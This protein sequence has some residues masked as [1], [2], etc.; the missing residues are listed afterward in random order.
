[1]Q[2]SFESSTAFT[3]RPS[4]WGEAN[5]SGTI[6]YVQLL[7]SPPPKP[8]RTRRAIETNT[9]PAEAPQDA[10][11]EQVQQAK[12]KLLQQKQ[13]IRTVIDRLIALKCEAELAGESYSVDSASDCFLF[14][15]QL[16]I[17]KRP[18]IYLLENGNFQSVWRNGSKEQVSLQFFGH[19]VVQFAM[20]ALR[21][22]QPMARI[23]GRDTIQ[24][25]RAKIDEHGCKHLIV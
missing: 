22:N 20:F 21:D 6:S 7:P 14:L 3:P 23:A 15:N 5:G 10:V 9:A 19:N 11:E 24:K 2:L 8:I 13:A 12:R 17:T 18:S 16:C 1:M 4:F 25:V